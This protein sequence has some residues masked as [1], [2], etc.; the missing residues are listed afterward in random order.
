LQLHRLE[1]TGY[2]DEWF[3]VFLFGR[4]IHCDVT[5]GRRMHTK[6][7]PEAR[8]AGSRLWVGVGKPVDAV[9]PGRQFGQSEVFFFTF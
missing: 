6:V 5:R 9:Q 1:V 2:L 3:A 8:I 4:R 7:A